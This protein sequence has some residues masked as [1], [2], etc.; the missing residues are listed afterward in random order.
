MCVSPSGGTRSAYFATSDDHF[1]ELPTVK[2]QEITT[3]GVGEG[4]S[5]A[6]R[7]KTGA[8]LKRFIHVSRLTGSSAGVSIM[9][10]L[11][12]HVPKMQK[13]LNFFT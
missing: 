13:G 10:K 9:V 4:L 3:V 7:E 8:A 6:I 2:V 1:V 11:P 12:L 5:E